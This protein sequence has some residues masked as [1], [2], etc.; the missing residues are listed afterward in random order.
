MDRDAPDTRNTAV[1][2]LA[3]G[4]DNY[5]DHDSLDSI[6]LPRHRRHA[7]NLSPGA[8]SRIRPQV[9]TPRHRVVRETSPHSSASAPSAQGTTQL[10][11]SDARMKRISSI[12]KTFS[13]P[14]LQPSQV[15]V[16]ERPYSSPGAQPPS[17]PLLRSHTSPSIPKLSPLLKRKPPASHSSYGIETSNGPPPSYSTQLT[18]SQERPWSQ[19]R[20]RSQKPANITSTTSDDIGT[21]QLT[22]R[23]TIVLEGCKPDP[24]HQHITLRRKNA[25]ASET[26][27]SA[28]PHLSRSSQDLAR[29]VRDTDECSSASSPQPEFLIASTR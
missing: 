12:A 29:N 8:A 22:Q 28:A 16:E 13:S 19:E 18:L 23:Q 24:L 25:A 3:A 17:T 6:A 20:G 4:L 21:A 14:N 2:S 5:F 7:S 1:S 26:S 10:S 15:D 11:R 9:V 27:I